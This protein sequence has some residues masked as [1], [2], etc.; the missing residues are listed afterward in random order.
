MVFG[1]GFFSVFGLDDFC[2]RDAIQFCRI[3]RDE[4]LF[5]LEFPKVKKEQTRNSRVF[6][7]MYFLNPC[8][9]SGIVQFKN[10]KTISDD[11]FVAV[12]S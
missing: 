12:E 5:C 2:S 4:L 9:F 8:L 1:L 10:K 6:S 3:C 7:K 11:I